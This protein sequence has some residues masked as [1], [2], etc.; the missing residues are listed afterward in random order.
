MLAKKISRG[1][2]NPFPQNC[3]AKPSPHLYSR[4][5]P[6]PFGKAL[7]FAQRRLS[8]TDA[9]LV[10]VRI[11]LEKSSD[12]VQ[13]T[14]PVQKFSIK[15]RY[16][17]EIVGDVII[18]EKSIGLAF[19]L[20]GLGGYRTQPG[21]QMIAQTFFENSYSVVNFDATNSTG[22]SGGGYE[23]A[24]MQAHYEDLVD[25]ID[26]SKK[27]DWY[28]EPFV[29]AGHSLGGYAVARYAEDH[30]EVVQ[31]V[32]PFA[33]VVNGELSWKAN[34]HSGELQKWK[35]SGW[36]VSESKSRPG[37][38]KRLP[39][40]HMEERLKHDL[41]PH[42][43]QLTMPTLFLMGENDSSCPPDHEKILYDLVPGPKEF[44]VVA[45]APHTFR[46]PEH[47]EQ[48]KSILSNWIKKLS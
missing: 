26:W 24:T 48:L 12:F 19:V 36:R 32:F 38:I 39:W 40:S 1:F 3:F 44:H 18:A 28:M 31:A 10:L 9:R 13:E 4:F 35:E 30:P 2:A 33:L 8:A 21:M 27:Q 41:L 5:R 20:H 42:A 23:H 15:N 7:C 14:Q 37:V 25:V 29:L 45:G 16:G 43:D 46:T 6:F 47:L 17:L 34:E 22:D 11:V